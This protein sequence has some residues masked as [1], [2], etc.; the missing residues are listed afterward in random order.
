VQRVARAESRPGGAVG[1]GL[2]VL[3]GVAEG[4]DEAAAD[5]LAAK[6]AKLRIFE[7]DAGKFDRSLLDTGGS[8]LVVSQ[9]TLIADTAKGNR[10][11]FTHAATPDRAEELYERF[12]SALRALGADVEQ[13]VFGARMEVELV[14]DGPVTIILG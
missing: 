9:F 1:P 3:L 4:D 8:A 13:G 11:S 10:P 5:A 14:N 6:V 12:C 2:L 7:N